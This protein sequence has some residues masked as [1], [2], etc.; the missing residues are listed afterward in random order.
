MVVIF[1]L[2][3]A[4]VAAGSGHPWAALVLGYWAGWAAARRGLYFV[5]ARAHD[6]R[7]L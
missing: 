3:G 5:S 2:I 4:A 1:C 7:N 6:P